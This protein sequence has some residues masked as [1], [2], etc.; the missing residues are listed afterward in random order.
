MCSDSVALCCVYAVSIIVRRQR[1]TYSTCSH[2]KMF[3][4]VCGA[5]A[6][7]TKQVVNDSRVL[8]AVAGPNENGSNHFDIKYTLASHSVLV[9]TTLPVVLC[10]LLLYF[11]FDTTPTTH[12]RELSQFLV[13]YSAFC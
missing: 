5:D 7:F 13:F 11:S 3:S 10:Q 12:F 1:P 4:I 8:C 2:P 6:R 9:A